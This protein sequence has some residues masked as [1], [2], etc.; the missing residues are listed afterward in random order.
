MTTTDKDYYAILGVGEKAGGDEIKKAY[1]RLAKRYHPDANRNDPKAADRFKEVGEAHSVLSDPAKRKKYDHM[2]R[3]G[4]FGFGGARGGGPR[5]SP[6][7]SSS[8]SGGFSF[9]DLGGLGGFSDIFSSI[10]DRGK[11]DTASKPKGPRKGHN[12]EYRVEVGFM[13]AANGGRVSLSVP[14]TEECATCSGSGGAPGTEW[15]PCDECRGSGS[16]SFGQGGFAVKRPCPACV[17]R[18]R[19]AGRPCE[20]CRG[21]GEVHQ[22]RKIQ[23]AVP[24]GVETGSNVRLTGQGERGEK[25]G[26]PGDLVITFKVKSHRRFR[27]DGLDVHVKVAVNMAQAILGSK[28]SVDTISGQRVVLRLPPGTQSGTRFRIRGQGVRGKGRTG[29][30]FVEV[31][32]RVPDSLTGEQ[33]DRIKQFAESAGLEW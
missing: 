26:A 12:V 9:E 17:G 22:N 28:L 29:D 33:E 30:Q 11:K 19:K 14:I 6:A 32:V 31:V 4:A 20:A 23:V 3:L 27:R 18:G 1:R 13:T 2:R 10:F 16:V 7:T 8:P 15:K 24:A 25:G 5:S 21:A